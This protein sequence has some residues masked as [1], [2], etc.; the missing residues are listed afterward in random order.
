MNQLR[1]A[2]FRRMGRETMSGNF[3]TV[4][5]VLLIQT[6]LLSALGATFVGSIIV[7]GPLSVGVAYVMLAL[8]RRE[9]TELGDM[10]SGF[11][12]GF[13]DNMVAGLLVSVFTALWSLL[14]II[15]GIVKALSYSMTYYILSDNPGTPAMEAIERSQ[16]MMRGHKWQLFCLQLSFIG[17][18]LLIGIT[19]GLAAIYVAPYMASTTAAF[20]QKLKE[21]NAPQT[22]Q[23]A[24]D[25]ETN[26]QTNDQPND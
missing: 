20:Y 15:P 13:A 22:T 3:G 14:F 5:L 2:D 16:E 6:A 4:F 11:R 17:W 7:A 25:T 10:F 24:E 12:S 21:E 19:C 18:Y 23:T 26:E 1:A 8:T 9:N